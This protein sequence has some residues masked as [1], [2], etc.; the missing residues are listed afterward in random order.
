M[1]NYKTHSFKYSEKMVTMK[2]AKPC[3]E[4]CEIDIEKKD[5]SHI[6]I[7]EYLDEVFRELTYFNPWQTHTKRFLRHKTKI[8]GAREAF[9][10]SGIYDQD[11]GERITEAQGT[12]VLASSDNEEI[13]LL[14][15]PEQQAIE[16]ASIEQIENLKK[17]AGQAKLIDADLLDFIVAQ[18]IKDPDRMTM[19]EYQVCLQAVMAKLDAD[20]KK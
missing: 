8:Q 2:G 15:S 6:I 3:P 12:E 14:A 5:G 1:E 18:G 17:I 10:F 9:G 16:L 11:E 20:T 7:R 13:P 4:W 19:K